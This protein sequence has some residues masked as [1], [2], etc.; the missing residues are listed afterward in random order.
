MNEAIPLTNLLSDDGPDLITHDFQQGDPRGLIPGHFTVVGK[1]VHW[2]GGPS[3]LSVTVVLDASQEVLPGQMLAVWHGARARNLL[4]AVQVVDCVEVNPNEDPTLAVPRERLGIGIGYA[5]EGQ[6]TRIFRLATCEVLEEF[7]VSD[8]LD[9]RLEILSVEAPQ[10][11][12]RAGDFAFLLPPAM[13]HATI[14][15][16]PDPDGGL[17]MGK[18]LGGE[19]IEVT[20]TP[21][22]LQM[23]VGVF[24]NP[25]KGKSYASGVLLEEAHRWGVPILAIDVNGEMVEA[26]KSLGGLTITLPDSDQ[27]GLSLNLLTPTELS[28]ITPNVKS[29]TQY[30]ELIEGA[31]EELLSSIGRKQEITFQDLLDKIQELGPKL[32]LKKASVGAALA[33]VRML[34]N[35]RLIGRGFDFIPTLIEKKIVVLDCRYLTLRQTQLITATAARVLQK[36]GKEMA[37]QAEEGEDPASREKGAAWFSL[38]FVDEAHAVAPASDDVVS[39]QVLYELAR[40]GRHVRTGLVLSS[41]SPADLDSSILKRLQ[42]RLIFSLERDQLRAISGVTADLN[43]KIL[44]QLPKLS[45]GV[46]A[47]SG[48]SELIRHGFLLRI[49]KRSTPVG[50]TTPPIFAR[51]QKADLK[52]GTP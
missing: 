6:S 48:T 37:R 8:I 38:L 45:R 19:S 36:Y 44:A 42:T 15:S 46:C 12:T 7:T 28:Y 49:K 24:G 11:L 20:L 51:R 25:G 22:V 29:G 27:F 31:H 5:K 32:D 50:G 14:N 52:G 4:S 21:Q 40:M 17:H 10:S 33:R 13:A 39:T 34:S 41:Q 35:D 43:E 1:L 30:A 47:V 3:F 16:D 2:Q 18:T 26:A 9:P 23:H